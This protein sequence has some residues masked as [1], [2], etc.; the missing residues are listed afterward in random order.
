MPGLHGCKECC[1]GC[2]VRR[3]CCRPGP[4]EFAGLTTD[5]ALLHLCKHCDTLFHD[6]EMT[7]EQVRFE[8]VRILHAHAAKLGRAAY[9]RRRVRALE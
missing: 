1:A 8:V 2:Q 5:G 3:C 7:L 4:A 9:A 6:W